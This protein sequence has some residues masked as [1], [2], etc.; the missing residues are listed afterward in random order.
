LFNQIK[1]CFIKEYRYYYQNPLV[2]FSILLNELIVLLVFWYTA[3]AFVPNLEIFSGKAI[4]YFTFIVIGETALR[5]PSFFITIVSRNMKNA[6]LDGAFENHLLLKHSPQYAFFIEGL[7]AS[8]FEILKVAL[9][10]FLATVFFVIDVTF[11]ALLLAIP[12]QLISILI[13]TG[14]GLV[15]VSILLV[16]KRGEGWLMR[17]VSIATILAGAYFPTTVLPYGL[18]VHL[19]YASPFNLLLE[20][21]RQIMHEQISYHTYF[22]SCFI[23]SIW[24]V[25]LLTSGYILFSKA[26]ELHKKSDR[27]FTYLS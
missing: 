25:I 18:N 14:L 19:H 15:S 16:L 20:S 27:P 8:I 17:L 23:L 12:I 13:F 2:L 5:I 3:K 7:C 6:T 1:I 10:L 11:Y 9:V 24:A 22:Q 26:L 21:T 4:D